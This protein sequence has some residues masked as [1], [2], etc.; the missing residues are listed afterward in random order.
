[1]T[2]VMDGSHINGRPSDRIEE[3][4][5]ASGVEGFENSLA[6]PKIDKG[7]GKAEPEPKGLSPSIHINDSDDDD[8]DG[9]PYEDAVE[10]GVASPTVRSRSWVAEE[11][12]VFRKGTVLLGPAEMEG[13]YAG[14]E[15]RKELLEAMVERPPPRPLNDEFGMEVMQSFGEV[16]MTGDR[17]PISSMATSLPP[18]TTPKPAPKPYISRTKSSSNSI[19]NLISPVSSP[20]KEYFE[21]TLTPTTPTMEGRPP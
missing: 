17:S 12:E 1:M 16:P 11:G 7:K 6:T 10:G 18:E 8:D 3:S 15:L 21:T 9:V 5:E 2:I 19:L 14:E 4:S 20:S 13:E